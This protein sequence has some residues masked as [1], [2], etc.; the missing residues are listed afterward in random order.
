MD[1]VLPPYA[2]LN[3]KPSRPSAEQRK[4]HRLAREHTYAMLS[5]GMGVGKSWSGAVHFSRNILSNRAHLQLTG[6]GLDEAVYLAA[7]PTYQL[8]KAGPWAHLLKILRDIENINGFS[9][10]AC[11]PKKSNPPEIRLVT[12]DVI[13]FL[14]TDSGRYAGRTCAGWW[15]DECDHPLNAD[16]VGGFNLVDDRLRDPRIEHLSGICTSTPPVRAVGVAH[17][18]KDME[19]AGNK[20][21][22]IVRAAS[23]SNPMNQ[24]T[25]Y[26]ER[27]SATM[28]E[29][30]RQ[31]KLEGKVLKPT[32]T[33]YAE[34]FDPSESI[35]WEWKWYGGPRKDCEY[36]L[37]IDWPP[38]PAHCLLVEYNPQSG[39]Y[40]V[41]DEVL[42]EGVSVD[43]F[44]KT[45]VD[46]CKQK[47]KIRRD[48][49]DTVYCDAM[50]KMAREVAS[51]PRFWKGAVRYTIIR[52][53]KG[54]KQSGIDTV[55]FV[56]LDAA[57]V[58]RLQFARRLRDTP[59]KR[60]ILAC[61]SNYQEIQTVRDGQV[62]STGRFDN[63]SPW[64]HGPDALRYMFWM[65]ESHRRFYDP[66]AQVA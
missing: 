60:G 6:H 2:V 38:G 8:V 23:S 65:R 17:M 47:W 11:R 43:S 35:N 10:L 9:L 24:G 31:I 48:H 29:R 28:S 5:G 15:Y 3:G 44:C 33:V 45:I 7:A 34:E 50:P 26:V 16:P 56:L 55:R 57:G 18:F 62:T 1:L 21:F 61:M 51:S 32:G 37:A 58:R 14:S 19:A 39:V 4:F 25:D 66:F 22:A 41:F 36:F 27:R 46:R 12:G 53:H 54:E 52:G 30:E 20:N 64:G 59:Q 49:I 40:T 42:A 63:A 13:E